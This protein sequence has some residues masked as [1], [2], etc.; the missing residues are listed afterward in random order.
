MSNRYKCRNVSASSRKK[1]EKL[2]AIKLHD[3]LDDR[4]RRVRPE[5]E[6]TGEVPI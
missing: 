3:H 4:L 5:F 2:K 6:R 1:L